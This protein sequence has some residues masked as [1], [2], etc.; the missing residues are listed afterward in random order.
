MAGK[1]ANN[2]NHRVDLE[3]GERILR[4]HMDIE[5]LSHPR[6]V[7]MDFLEQQ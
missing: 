7:V 3:K 6:M 2:G 4:N 5:Q 1:K